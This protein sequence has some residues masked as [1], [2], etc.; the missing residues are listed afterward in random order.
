M[1]GSSKQVYG[2]PQAERKI[3]DVADPVKEEVK[4]TVKAARDGAE[5]VGNGDTKKGEFGEGA[6][7]VHQ[8]ETDIKDVVDTV[9][10]EAKNIV[11][12]LRDGA[13]G[14]ANGDTKKEE[15]GGGTK[16]VRHEVKQTAEDTK[17][18]AEI[19]TNGDATAEKTTGEATQNLKDGVERTGG[20]AEVGMAQVSNDLSVAGDQFSEL[21]EKATES[22][23][24][25][26]GKFKNGVARASNGVS[27]GINEVAARIEEKVEEKAQ[28]TK[29][30]VSD[31]ATA[32]HIKLSSVVDGSLNALPSTIASSAPKQTPQP[33]ASTSTSPSTS[34]AS[35]TTFAPALPETLPTPKTNALPANRKRKTPKDFKPSGPGEAAAPSSPSKIGVKFEDGVAPGQGLEGERTMSPRRKAIVVEE[36]KDRNMIERT[37]WTFIMIGGFIGEFCVL[38]EDLAYKVTSPLV[39]GTSV[40]DTAGDVVSDIGVQGGHSAV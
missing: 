40:Y 36:K 39:P 9:K 34:V 4:E 10:G 16:V 3:Q 19:L 2:E 33:E 22:I 5:E 12:D 30:F 23:S 24:E 27:N 25:A 32:V 14:V 20:K 1:E 8:A 7:A 17:E 15:I 38:D 11:E 28:Q 13:E 29:D 26:A 21:G 6:K 31:T 37:V 35:T 18:E